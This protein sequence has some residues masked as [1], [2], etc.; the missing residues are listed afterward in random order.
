MQPSNTPEEWRPVVGY[1]DRYEVSSLGNVRSKAYALVDAR[2]TVHEK[3]PRTRKLHQRPSGHMQ[4]MLTDGERRYNAHVHRLMM[5]AF[6]GPCPEGMEVCHNNGVAS[7]NR[8]E[9]LRYGTRSENNQDTLM[10]GRN[11]NAE[12]SHCSQGHEYDE[13]NTFL[14]PSGGRGCRACRSKKRE[15]P[16]CGKFIRTGNFRHHVRSIHERAGESI[17]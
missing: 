6:V 16:N 4:V 14:R 9:N 8:L 7:D 17:E 11:V 3:S 2:G 1:E 10:H 15:C 12:K 5:A 13:G